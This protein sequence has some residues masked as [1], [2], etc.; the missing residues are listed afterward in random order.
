[1]KNRVIFSRFCQFSKN[2]SVIA[3]YIADGHEILFGNFIFEYSRIIAIPTMI[4]FGIL[5]LL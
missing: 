3:A 5:R 2:C 4:S 1:M